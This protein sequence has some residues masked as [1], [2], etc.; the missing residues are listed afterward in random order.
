[1]LRA[2]N[3]RAGFTLATS[4]A[5]RS[6]FAIDERIFSFYPRYLNASFAERIIVRRVEGEISMVLWPLRQFAEFVSRYV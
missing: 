3:T 1:M 4:L 2:R 6:L 5:N